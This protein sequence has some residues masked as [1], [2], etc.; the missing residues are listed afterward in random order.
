MKKPVIIRRWNLK[1]SS[2]GGHT[3][4]GWRGMCQWPGLSD[5]NGKSQKK[6][7]SKKVQE[8]SLPA[9][10]RI[11]AGHSRWEILNNL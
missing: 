2:R 6:K 7:K 11:P 4:A 10:I 3:P 8:N 5:V 1:N 9:I